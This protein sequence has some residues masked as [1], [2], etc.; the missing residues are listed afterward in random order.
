MQFDW[1]LSVLEQKREENYKI[2][3]IEAADKHL[4]FTHDVLLVKT[5]LIK[6]LILFSFGNSILGVQ[7]TII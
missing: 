3:Y 7:K 1:F 2:Y 4:R 5:W 6:T